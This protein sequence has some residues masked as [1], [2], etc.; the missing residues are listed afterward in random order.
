M[1]CV[2][3]CSATSRSAARRSVCR[4]STEPRTN[5]R[6]SPTEYCTITS[7]DTSET[8]AD[9]LPAVPPAGAARKFFLPGLGIGVAVGCPEDRGRIPRAARDVARDQDFLHPSHRMHVNRFDRPWPLGMDAR[10]QGP[11]IICPK[12]RRMPRSSGP[13]IVRQL[14]DN[15]VAMPKTVSGVTA[16]PSNW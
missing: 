14:S 11:A 16:L 12:R 3:K 7:A 8:P 13:T 10:G 9:S 1:S 15:K 4:L 5:S 6:R 2:A